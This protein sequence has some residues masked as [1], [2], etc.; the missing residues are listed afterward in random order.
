MTVLHLQKYRDEDAPGKAFLVKV[1]AWETYRSIVLG[2]PMNLDWMM[3]GWYNCII[4]G[5][6]LD[7]GYLYMSQLMHPVDI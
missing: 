6:D 4:G 3:L 1:M 2:G 7:M 5:I